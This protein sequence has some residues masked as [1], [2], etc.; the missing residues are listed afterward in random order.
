MAVLVQVPAVRA[1][2]KPVGT[3]TGKY[4]H[5]ATPQTSG[6][7]TASLSIGK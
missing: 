2:P 6:R 1:A 4:T 7:L 5:S 3:R